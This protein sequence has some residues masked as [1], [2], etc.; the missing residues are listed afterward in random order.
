MKNST[1]LNI[2]KHCLEKRR[3]MYSFL[4]LFFLSLSAFFLFINTDVHAQQTSLK[5]RA[6]L[7]TCYASPEVYHTRVLPEALSLR[8]QSVSGTLAEVEAPPLKTANFEVTYNGF[9]PEA[10]AAFQ[11]AVDIWS[12]IIKSDVT[13]KISANFTSLSPGVLGSAGPNFIRANFGEGK[14]GFWY[15][16][17]LADAL[18]GEDLNPDPTAPDIF[19][20]FNSDFE[21]Y[22]GTDMNPASNE[23]D[24]VSVVLHEI[25]HGLGFTGAASVN[26]AGTGFIRISGL[27]LAYNDFAVNGEGTSILSFPDPSME[28]GDQLTSDDLFMAGENAVA[29]LS[30]SAT[31]VASLKTNAAATEMP[32]LYVPTTWRQGSSYSHWDEDTYVAGDINSLMSPMFGFAEA[33]HNVGPITKGLFKDMGWEINEEP[34]TL[35]ALRQTVQESGGADCNTLPVP[36]TDDISVLPN[37]EVCYYYTVENVGDVTLTLH[38]LMDTENGVILDDV[39]FELTPGATATVFQ[40][41]YVGTEPVTNIAT[42]TAFNPGPE[43]EVMATAVTN[44]NSGPAASVTPPILLEQLPLGG[45]SMQEMSL[46]NEGNRELKYKIVIREFDLPFEEIVANSNKAVEE[47]LKTAKIPEISSFGSELQMQLPAKGEASALAIPGGGDNLKII[48]YATDF[49]DFEL[50]ELF[51]QDGWFNSVGYIISLNTFSNNKFLQAISDGT[52][53]TTL[54]FSPNVGIGSEPFSSFAT[55][56][57]VVGDGTTFQIIPQSPEVGSVVTRIEFATDGFMYLLVDGPGWV[58]TGFPTPKGTFDLQMIVDRS[59]FEFSIYIDGELLFDGVPGFAGDI[60]EVALLSLNEADGPVMNIDDFVILDGDLGAPDWITVNPSA[61]MVD[62]MSSMPIDV[63][64]DADGLEPGPYFASI[65]ILNNDPDNSLIAVPAALLVTSKV[66]TLNM[67]NAKTE[68]VIRPMKEQDVFNLAEIGTFAVNIQ[69]VTTPGTIG[70][71]VFK[72]NGKVHRIENQAPYAMF[73]DTNGDYETWYPKPGVYTVE[74]IPFSEPWGMGFAG[75]S[76]IST[77]RI[78]K[79]KDSD[80]PAARLNVYPNPTMDE[81]NVQL[82]GE[83]GEE[84]IISLLNQQ[85]G[86]TY[87][88]NQVKVESNMA[89]FK[90]NTIGLPK[91]N[92]ILK[93]QSEG[94]TELIRISKE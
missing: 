67:I 17:A 66:M 43:N 85:S 44:V 14:Q 48:D 31:P 38:D 2:S 20:Q 58:N 52:G 22:Y 65:Y 76:M 34:V 49:E 86:I 15:V 69:A 68:E 84:I 12:T 73:G 47:A 75:E 36:E 40:A 5:Q 53:G 82:K 9:T 1:T 41:G 29:A 90:I 8:N 94:T 78:K 18:Y 57:N 91:G 79:R 7:D 74:A 93:V 50:G 87:F 25:G 26:P 61:G 30:M 10:Q 28:L 13:I 70:S 51:G 6:I 16:D 55:T 42:W 72:L 24:F 60:E 83:M 63:Y 89:E 32:K 11:Y 81:L 27:P 88:T 35:I 37:T 56:V 92:H 77:F 71:V 39:E 59:T 19:A 33:V 54:A 23:I 80:L 4:K 62:P 46:N 45:A 3:T 64:F 21:W